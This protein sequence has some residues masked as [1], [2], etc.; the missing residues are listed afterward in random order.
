MT[1]YLSSYKILLES[2]RG[3]IFLYITFL[4]TGTSIGVPMIG[5]DCPTC[6]SSDPKNRRYRSSIYIE[7]DNLKLLIDTPPEMRLQFL[8]N[9]ITEVNS[10]LFT[11]A[12]A[13]HIMGF[14]DIRAINRL[15]QEE[16]PCYGNQD[17]IKEIERIFDYI[18]NTSQIGGGI[19]RVI[20]NTVNLTFKISNV[21]IIPLPVKHGELDILGYKIGEMAYITDCS[22]IPSSTMNLLSNIEVLIIDALRYKPHP[23]HMNIEEVLS[24]IDKLKVNKAY[25]T[26]LSHDLEHNNVNKK[27]PANV[28]LAY[29]KFRIKV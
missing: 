8:E 21:T 11:H 2:K 26:H 4:G 9:N 6:S 20:L 13:D 29:D 10:I 18:F 27:L 5:C 14:D 19:P 16:I 12:H 22:H 28:Q 3:G 7:I 1:K 17:T 25:L 24:I 15:Q 23:T